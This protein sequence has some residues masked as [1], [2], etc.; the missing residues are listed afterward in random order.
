M[1]L[2]PAIVRELFLVHGL[3]HESARAWFHCPKMDTVID[4]VKA[5]GCLD[6]VFGLHPI[7]GHFVFRPIQDEWTVVYLEN[8]P[9]VSPKKINKTDTVAL[10]NHLFTEAGLPV[11]VH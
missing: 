3:R 5:R 6:P 10:I 8:P 2:H 7:Y 4:Y 9:C 1:R 11:V